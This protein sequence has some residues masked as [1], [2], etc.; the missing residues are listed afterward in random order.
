MSE[1]PP[2]E[3]RT[4]RRVPRKTELLLG[5]AI[6]F[7][8]AVV[9]VP[10]IETAPQPFLA[11]PLVRNLEELLVLARDEAA[12]SGDEHI[13]LLEPTGT[14]S[15]S[16]VLLFRDL[17]GDGR[18]SEAERIASVGLDRTEGLG[19]GA[20]LAR[21]PANGDAADV[22]RTPW[23]FSDPSVRDQPLGLVFGADGAPHTIAAS[24][25]RGAAGSGAGSLYLH[26]PT[27]DY[28]VVLS[29]WGDV[30]V[31]IWD[32]ASGS[33][34]LAAEPGSTARRARRGER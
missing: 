32:D 29:P 15:E 18:A 13:V 27:R 3:E 2:L 9:A 11:D 24:G 6:A 22:L 20:L 28:A 4:P 21:Q 5:I 31:Q 16:M 17:D 34:Q 33:W 19:W 26:S 7:V 1:T 8:L 25:V 14:F 10:G 23:S 30:E 12:N